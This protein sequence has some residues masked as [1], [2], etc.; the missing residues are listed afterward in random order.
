MFRKLATVALWCTWVVV[1]LGF[2]TRPVRA[3]V[4]TGGIEGVVTDVSGA[5]IAGAAITIEDVDTGILRK[6]VSDEQG[7]FAVP[8][9]AIGNYRV[10]AER[11]GFSKQIQQG[12]VLA[13]GQT[14][15]V[16]FKM[17]VGSIAQ[18]VTVSET[19]TQLVDTT[20]SHIGTL[21]GTQQ[22]QQLP[23]NGR[24]FQQLVGL[25][26][27]VA[28]VSSPTSGANF[29]SM[30]RYSVAGARTDAGSF[31]LDGVEIRDF[32]G[33][34]AGLTI[35]GTSLGV[36][37]I[38]Q[39]QVITNSGDAQY[40]GVSTI[41]EV[42]KSGTN[43][44]HGE[45]YSY[46]R[47]SAM[48]ARNYFD[49][50][51]GPPE[52]HRYQFGGA[53]GGPIRKDKTFFFGNYEGIQS[54]LAL[55]NV[56]KVPDAN[57]HN[58]ILPCV[59]LTAA[60]RSQASSGCNGGS[61]G[62]GNVGVNSAVAP[63]LALYPNYGANGGPALPPGYTDDP[64]TGT[65]TFTSSG[66]Q[67]VHE[68]YYAVKVDQ[69]FSTKNSFSARYVSDRGEQIDPWFNG[70]AS[71]QPGI[72]PRPG[73]ET[74]PEANMYATLQDRHI[75]SPSLINIATF[76]FVRTSQKQVINKAAVPAPLF[77]FNSLNQPG[78]I[79]ITNVASM[80]APSY[81]PLQQ[82][83]NVFTEQDQVDW[84][85]GAHT[86]AFGIAFA[87]YDCNCVQAST[88]GGAWTF[89]SLDAFLRNQPS[90]YQ[91]E[92]P[93]VAGLTGYQA[94]IRYG[95]Q[96]NVSFFATDQ[97]KVFK[98]LIINIGIRDDYITNPTEA[99]NNFYHI[100]HLD[101][102]TCSNDT[103][104]GTPEPGI[105]T[106]FS[107][108]PNM[109]ATNPSTR[110]IDPRFGFNWDVFGNGRTSFR[111]GY[112]IY[113]DL[114]YPH[115]YTVGSGFGYPNG[116]TQISTFNATTGTFP[117]PIP[118]NIVPQIRTVPSYNT[119]CTAYFQE[120]NAA[121][122]QQLPNHFMLNVS[123]V[124]S[125]GIHLYEQ[126]NFNTNIPTAGTQFRPFAPSTA[127]GGGTQAA[128]GLATKL[129]VCITTNAAYNAA[130]CSAASAGFGVNGAGYQPNTAFTSVQFF[131]PE[132]NS[133]YNSGVV[134]V[135]RSFG[136]GLN[137][138]SAFTFA[139]CLDYGSV[140]T[141]GPELGSESTMWVYPLT[142]K[143]YN[144]G[145]CAFN[146]TKNWTT[147]VLYPLPFHGNQL[148]S[149]WQL[150]MISSV[151]TGQ[152]VT[153]NLPSSIDISNLGNYVFDTERPNVVS[154]YTGPQYLK[155]KT[156]GTVPVVNWFGPSPYSMPTAGLLGN[157]GRMSIV[158]PNYVTV[159]GS[160][161]KSTR[162]PKM[163]E[164]GALQLRA[165]FFNLANHANFSLPN[166]TIYAGSL[167]APTIN[168]TVGQISSTVGTARQ[169]QFSA[170]I[171]F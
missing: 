46:F 15:T 130:A 69:Q 2:G 87:K 139:R 11:D 157:A 72:I 85:K 135:K 86:M 147:S 26:P 88:A 33:Q 64:T 118:Q 94:S 137:L 12:L 13:I 57:A 24:N 119:C 154:G 93:A 70:A 23:L 120:W 90:Q 28:A 79:A 128:I 126:Q 41:S 21:V 16:N 18:E 77:T 65:A 133:N 108:T 170:T 116:T 75:F 140:T 115:F 8:S 169:L 7:R 43:Q 59:A 39:F 68:N 49:P 67:P 42:T 6:V 83:Q 148:V 146:I 66:P 9:L 123:Y 44:F 121:I 56:Q 36:S 106:G 80:N 164:S 29:G 149:G 145:P 103:F 163:G 4:Q 63:F 54:L 92:F 162:L 51:S 132:G 14:L 168:T 107:H 100:T 102:L 95:R 105:S 55:N 25:A 143:R 3:Q 171:Q 20:S 104:C 125:N 5:V 74:D 138:F 96:L 22:I 141:G 71:G 122:E 134:S 76:A 111:G 84:I 40:H 166:S 160:I 78:S 110:N 165:D 19:A 91:G 142:S 38:D 99:T 45:A 1:I 52:F 109:F 113:H 129:P 98:R 81:E 151:R 101:P 131:Q 144:Y 32:W 31:L 127:N 124:G 53:I 152:P 73:A 153:P 82:I 27:G 158:G 61:T 159:D 34:G 48:D 167:T 155:Q 89:P 50:V 117:T 17:Q 37:S 35:T 60:E 97:W 30:Q 161:M 62:N 58:G 136:S 47:N 150:G 10:T 114:I 112:G 156:A